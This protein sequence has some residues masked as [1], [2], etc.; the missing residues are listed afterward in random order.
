M[1]NII[2]ALFLATMIF[3]S[4]A[5][6]AENEQ[7]ESFNLSKDYTVRLISDN[8]GNIKEEALFLPLR[9]SCESFG[10]N[11]DWDNQHSRA[12]VAQGNSDTPMTSIKNEEVKLLIIA[13]DFSFV[14][15]VNE[16]NAWFE[17]TP[18]GLPQGY[19]AILA[20]NGRLY[21]HS[22]ILDKYLGIK[23][24]VNNEEK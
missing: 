5:F 6:A 11:V 4:N 18:D 2:I 17:P 7:S 22:S 10:Y 14:E 12:I 23:T 1:K 8:E 21:V 16:K 24:N 15:L 3:S 9:K 19:E 20:Q 13:P